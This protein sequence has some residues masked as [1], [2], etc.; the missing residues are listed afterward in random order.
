MEYFLA[1]AGSLAVLLFEKQMLVI[2]YEN[3]REEIC[4]K[5]F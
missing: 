2:N 4:R 3:L 1:F 5:N